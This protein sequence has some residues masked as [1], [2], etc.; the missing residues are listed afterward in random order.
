MKTKNWA[1]KF[2][3]TYHRRRVKRKGGWER[4]KGLN[5]NF[6]SAGFRRPLTDMVSSSIWTA[7]LSSRPCTDCGLVPLGRP[8]CFVIQTQLKLF[9]PT[10]PPKRSLCIAFWFHLQVCLRSDVQNVSMSGH[11]LIALVVK[12][13]R[14]SCVKWKQWRTQS[15]PTPSPNSPLYV[16]IFTWFSLAC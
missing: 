12:I 16:Y 10:P 15:I 8:L 2:L 11:I 13:D 9:W 14:F 1:V 3:V 6:F 4:E 5:Y 7:P